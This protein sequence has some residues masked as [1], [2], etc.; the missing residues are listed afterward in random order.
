MAWRYGVELISRRSASVF[1]HWS[2]LKFTP[3][4]MGVLTGLASCIL[5]WCNRSAVK[6]LRLS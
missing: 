1:G 5:Y 6:P 2:L 4:C 3:G